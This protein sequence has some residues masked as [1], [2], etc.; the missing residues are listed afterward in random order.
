MGDSATLGGFMILA[1]VL[2]FIGVV[3]A[4]AWVVK[5]GLNWAEEFDRKRDI[6]RQ[7]RQ[8]I[9]DTEYQKKAADKIL[10]D[11]GQRR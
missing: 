6:E 11:F 8:S 10:R 1:V 5:K 9:R 4:G 2:V 7:L 3:I